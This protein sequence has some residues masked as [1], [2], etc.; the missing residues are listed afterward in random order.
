MK[1]M[2]LESLLNVSLLS[3][4]WNY[5]IAA[6]SVQGDLPK[7]SRPLGVKVVPD[8]IVYPHLRHADLDM[9]GAQVEVEVEVAGE[10]LQTKEMSALEVL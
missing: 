8:T 7:L 6:L 5:K 10:E 9:S 2:M 4:T 1:L 3:P